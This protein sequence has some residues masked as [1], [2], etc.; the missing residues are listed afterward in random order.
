MGNN[1]SMDKRARFNRFRAI[2]FNVDAHLPHGEGK[3]FYKPGIICAE[4]GKQ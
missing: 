1:A 4:G 2:I 3:T